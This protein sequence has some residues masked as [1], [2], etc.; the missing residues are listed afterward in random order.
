M[1]ILLAPCS[2]AASGRVG[3]IQETSVAVG[4]A[5]RGR[6]RWPVPPEPREDSRA[7]M[8]TDLKMPTD[9]KYVRNIGICAHI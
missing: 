4:A 5:P 6:G 8:A 3:P 2:T 7:A 1:K 9:L